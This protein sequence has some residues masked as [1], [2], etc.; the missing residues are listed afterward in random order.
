[1][2]SEP[3]PFRLFCH[4]CGADADAPDAEFLLESLA[5]VMDADLSLAETHCKT[6]DMATDVVLWPS[7]PGLVRALAEAGD[8]EP[9]E[10]ML[11]GRYTTLVDGFERQIRA[12]HSAW[13]E[14]EE[15]EP[16]L[17]TL[18]LGGIDLQRLLAPPVDR[19]LAV[20]AAALAAVRGARRAIEAEAHPSLHARIRIGHLTSVL[21][22]DEG[23]VL[24]LSVSGV[25]GTTPKPIEQHL[26]L[27][28]CFEPGERLRLTGKPGDVVPVI[29]FYLPRSPLD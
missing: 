13:T 19:P 10:A 3:N 1:M 5:L 24:H 14:T 7:E 16:L 26:A 27:A 11:L 18:D 6:C 29:H 4:G 23:A 25:A 12:H 9:G 2:E 22:L 28:L 20:P 8:P 21:S 17:A 15:M